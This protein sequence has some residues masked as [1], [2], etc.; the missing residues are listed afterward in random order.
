MERGWS[1]GPSSGTQDESCDGG[2]K[3]RQGV[4]VG[5]R[6]TVAAHAMQSHGSEVS[7][8][9]LDMFLGYKHNFNIFLI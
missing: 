9:F 8:F 2:A 3:A 4:P 7:P 1:A 5:M 6:H